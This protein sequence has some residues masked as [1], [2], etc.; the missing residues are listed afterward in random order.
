MAIAEA[1]YND[2][3]IDG[4]LG[5]EKIGDALASSK[6]IFSLVTADNALAAAT[7]AAREI[8]AG[9]FYFDCN[10]CA[11]GTKMAAAHHIQASGAI[12]VDTAILSPVS[13]ALHRTPLIL[14][15][16]QADE[17]LSVL[18][19][20]GM[21]ARCIEGEVGRAS[22]VKMI[23]SVMVK[24]L[25]ALSLECM[26]TARKAGV[27]GEVLSSLDA[28]DMRQGWS[29]QIAY[30]LERATT[31]GIRRAAEMRE[32]ARTIEE[33]GLSPT[34]AT[35]TAQWQEQ[36]G[37]LSLALTAEDPAESADR[38]LAILASRPKIAR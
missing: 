11:P 23:R 28:S 6:V 29:H 5:V 4:V 35:A 7:S 21:N 13:P 32:V 27:D 20:L 15:G 9:S 19:D 37:S 10:S 2:F 33:L 3:R 1:K 34:M 14:S 24:G 12:Y 26:L 38:I 36:A 22:A 18:Q 30:N 31:H 8:R 16:P 17:A 25:E